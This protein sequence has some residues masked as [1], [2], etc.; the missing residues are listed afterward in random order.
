MTDILATVPT[1]EDPE[2]RYGP[3]TAFAALRLG[4]GRSVDRLR[5]H[6]SE[7]GDVN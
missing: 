6:L 2:R 3:T 1:F 5:A 7:D 4:I